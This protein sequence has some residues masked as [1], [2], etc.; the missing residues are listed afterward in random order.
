MAVKMNDR[1]RAV[2]LVD[3]PQ[4]RQS[5]GVIASKRDKSRQHLTSLGN[6]LLVGIGVWFAHQETIVTILDLLNRPGVI[7]PAWVRQPAQHLP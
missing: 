6:A 5:N 7:V 2:G 4:Q 1:D 3:A